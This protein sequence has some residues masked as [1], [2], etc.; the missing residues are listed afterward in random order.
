MKERKFIDFG[1]YILEPR[2]RYN[3]EIYGYRTFIKDTYLVYAY[4]GTIK[5]KHGMVNPGGIFRPDENEIKKTGYQFHTGCAKQPLVLKGGKIWTDKDHIGDAIQIIK[6]HYANKLLDMS[7]MTVVA[8][9][10]AID[11]LEA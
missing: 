1:S 3:G 2:V 5:I 10:N 11:I 8:V 7:H 9:N 6:E 4:K